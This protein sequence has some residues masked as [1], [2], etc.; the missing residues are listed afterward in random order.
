MKRSVPP[1]EWKF[2][3]DDI[4]EAIA[5]IRRYVKS[6]DFE[7][8]CADEKTIDAVCRNFTV[9]GEAAQRVPEAVRAANPEIP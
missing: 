6:L 4:L 5:K 7:A 2:R 9:I 8:F 3:L 1:S